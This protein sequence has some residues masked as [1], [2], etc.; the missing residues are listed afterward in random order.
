MRTRGWGRWGMLL[1]WL[2]ALTLPAFAGLISQEQEIEIGRQGARQLEA[3][4][5]VV[6]DLPVQERITRVGQALAARGQRGLPYVFKVLDVSEVNAL[7]FPGGFIYATRG[8]MDLMP[9]SELAFV[10]GHEVSHVERRH[11]VDQMEADLY[12]RI[13]LTALLALLGRNNVGEGTVNTVQIADAILNSQYSQEAEREADRD[14]MAL[15]ARAGYD[16][17]GAVAALETLKR[18]D[19]GQ[20]V[21]GFLNSLLGSHPLTSERIDAARKLAPTIPYERPQ[22]PG[23]V[24]PE[25]SPPPPEQPAPLFTPVP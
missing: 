19:G 22:A 21:P 4:Y 5:P 7:A 25:P 9:D 17:Q 16:P 3:R 15:M 24:R 10:L 13:G 6:T 11:S 2:F 14:G 1:G 20:E 8:L 18:S 12:K 23:P